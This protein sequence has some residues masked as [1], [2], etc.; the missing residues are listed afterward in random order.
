[1]F[2]AVLSVLYV[3]ALAVAVDVAVAVVPVSIAGISR[4]SACPNL[5]GSQMPHRTY[6]ALTVPI[7]SPDQ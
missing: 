3:N 2:I 6:D 1:L 4:E 5:A 7:M